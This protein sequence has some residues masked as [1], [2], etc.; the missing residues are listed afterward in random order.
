MSIVQLNPEAPPRI[1]ASFVNNEDSLPN[2][3]FNLPEYTGWPVN[4]PLSKHVNDT[5]VI[6]AILSTF[7]QSWGFNPSPITKRS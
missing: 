2:S 1:S 3:K 5:R 4:I 6:R 7:L